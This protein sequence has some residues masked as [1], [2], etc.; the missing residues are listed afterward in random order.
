[1]VDPA[2]IPMLSQC[3][4]TVSKSTK[5][6]FYA[7]RINPHG[8]MHVILMGRKGVDHKNGNGLDNRRDNLRFA[9]LSQNGINQKRRNGIKSKYKG[10]V[11]PRPEIGSNYW[12][13]KVTIGF[14][15]REFGK[16]ATELEAA[17]AY[18]KKAK[19]VY[20]EWAR[21]NFPEEQS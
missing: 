3:N 21:L 18:D 7:K 2:D 19:E 9:T 17:L 8:L 11:P 14:K 15:Q 13:F 5:G 6:L 10:V 20:G 4:W 12:R 16:Y 1:L